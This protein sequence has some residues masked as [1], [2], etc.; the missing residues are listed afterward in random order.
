MKMTARGE[1]SIVK[2]DAL[3]VIGSVSER[4]RAAKQIGETPDPR[5]ILDELTKRP[6]VR[7]C[8]NR[9]PNRGHF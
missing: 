5:E 1:T 7:G 8:A 9:A 4:L 6:P 2:K 3:K